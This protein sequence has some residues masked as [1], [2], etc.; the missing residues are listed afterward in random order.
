MRHVYQ[1][2]VC[3]R[4]SFPFKHAGAAALLSLV[5]SACG[6]KAPFDP[7]AD[8]ASV[9]DTPSSEPATESF[10]PLCDGSDG[11]VFRAFYEGGGQAFPGH[12]MQME[13]GY[14]SFAVDGQCRYF[15]SGG[16]D[17]DKP[18]ARS[19][20]WR[21][22]PLDDEI[23]RSLQRS[24]GGAELSG[25]DDCSPY[26]SAADAPSL[27]VASAQFSI[28]CGG[29]P[30]GVRAVTETIREHA[31]ALRARG[32]ALA[33]DLYF[34]IVDGANSDVALDWPSTIP[35]PEVARERVESLRQVI[36]AADAAPVRALRERWLQGSAIRTYWDTGIPVRS[37]E[38]L[39]RV[40]LRDAVPHE[41]ASGVLPLP[42]PLGPS[43][44]RPAAV[45]ECQ[46][47]ASLASTVTQSRLDS[48]PQCQVDADCQPYDLIG[49]DMCWPSC[50]EG[51]WG[52]PSYEA[53]ERA[54]MASPP[55]ATACQTFREQG[56]QVSAPGCPRSPEVIGSRCVDQR[57]I[58]IQ[59][60][61]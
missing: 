36:A 1:R 28:T 44:S 34:E 22:G 30:N 46:D 59:A 17:V 38:R 19:E 41:D 24:I 32:Q 18:D 43:A 12:G 29:M 10:S 54:V 60:T 6:G 13:N 61:E 31:A 57:C 56:C 2:I 8:L 16:F 23:A 5:A 7:D 25:L 45:R 21:E 53:A 4:M 9:G 11:L 26:Q 48:V 27:V 35:L 51:R 15:I 40:F 20:G 50:G 37:G 33:G 14:P 52:S 47:L 3:Q 58:P 39:V 42:P 49:V 55:V